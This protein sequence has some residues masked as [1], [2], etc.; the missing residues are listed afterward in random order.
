MMWLP[1]G[2]RDRTIF[3]NYRLSRIPLKLRKLS[4]P[5]SSL[6]HFPIR[7]SA[8]VQGQQREAYFDI[9]EEQ[10]HSLWSLRACPGVC[11][12]PRT[13]RSWGRTL[14]PWLAFAHNQGQRVAWG[15][16]HCGCSCCLLGNASTCGQ[17]STREMSCLEPTHSA[18]CSPADE[19][20]EVSFATAQDGAN[21]RRGTARAQGPVSFQNSS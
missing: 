11:R 10:A 12:P 13:P 9:C 4:C 5:P 20:S 17:G 15:N 18:S 21:S 14:F 8:C 1:W 3:Q 7:I 16:F 2:E 19:G 6:C